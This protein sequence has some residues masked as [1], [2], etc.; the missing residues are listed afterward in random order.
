MK[1]RL[2][3][4]KRSIKFTNIWQKTIQT[5]HKKIHQW[6]IKHTERCLSPLVIREIQIKT[7]IRHHCTL[8][9]IVK[10][11][12]LTIPNVAKGCTA[13]GTLRLC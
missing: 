11:K 4:L 7:T 12:G 1:Q 2:H 8:T 3:Y 6:L 5:L 10:I 13:T 9:R